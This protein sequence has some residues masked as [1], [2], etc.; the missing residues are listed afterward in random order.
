MAH[1]HPRARRGG[2][3]RPGAPRGPRLSVIRE[4]SFR[5]WTRA[6]LSGRIG[7]PG[8]VVMRDVLW[9]RSS[10]PRC[11]KCGRVPIASGVS[12]VDNAGVAHY[13]GLAT[14]G[15]IWACPVCSAKIRNARALEIAEAA[16]NWHRAGNTVL[17]VTFTV[18]HDIGHAAGRAAA[19]DRRELLVGDRRRVPG[20]GSRTGC[21][22][23]A[24]SGASRSRTGR[25]AGIR[26]C[27]SWCSSRDHADACALAAFGIH[28]RSKWRTVHHQGRIPGAVRAPRRQDRRLHV[29]GRGG[30]VHR[31][32]PGRQVARGTRWPGPT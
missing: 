28:V 22:S 7:V 15:S 8:A 21:R 20:C 14:C 32:D 1:H 18:P 25:T 19:G 4:T 24:R 3:S 16:G 10:L 29:G 9:H 17:M 6:Q 11:R 12:M 23:S 30:L 26:T 13:R 31:Q 27:T 5:P 2:R